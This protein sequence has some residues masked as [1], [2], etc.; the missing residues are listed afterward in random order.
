[1]ILQLFS[2]ATLPSWYELPPARLTVELVF[3]RKSEHTSRDC[4]MRPR[5]PERSRRPRL[6]IFPLSSSCYQSWPSPSS[7]SPSPYHSLNRVPNL[8]SDSVPF[9]VHQTAHR[10]RIPVRAEHRVTQRIFGKS[11]VNELGRRSL[12]I[13]QTMCQINGGKVGQAINDLTF[14]WVRGLTEGIQQG[15]SEDC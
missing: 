10:T 8:R 4:P 1:M 7:I 11:T 14:W 5:S 13:V 15:I 3:R 2:P 12:Q 9:V 6:D